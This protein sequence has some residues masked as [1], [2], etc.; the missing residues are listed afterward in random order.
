MTTSSSD[1]LEWVENVLLNLGQIM[2]EDRVALEAGI[3]LEQYPLSTHIP[4]ELTVSTMLSRVG[5]WLDEEDFLIESYFPTFIVELVPITD[6]E[7][8]L[9]KENEDRF[10]MACESGE[11]DFMNLCR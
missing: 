3:L 6:K 5:L 10:F 4:K 8:R 1:A 9:I 11:I 7:V 2:L